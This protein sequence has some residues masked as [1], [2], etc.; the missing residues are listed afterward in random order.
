MIFCI[1]GT[2]H[3]RCQEKLDELKNSFIQKK[4]K[5]GV[6]IVHLEYI[7]KTR[8]KKS[9]GHDE[10]FLDN[11]KQEALATSFLGDKKLIIVKNALKD[12]KDEE[13]IIT[14]LKNNE[15]TIENSLC[16][17]DLIERPKSKKDYPPK[18]ALFHYL[19]GQKFKWEFTELSDNDAL[20]WIKN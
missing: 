2:D 11:L 16:F 13:A 19:S 3:Y 14:F 15:A 4:D 6:N 9:E 5:S 1:Y 7:E 20:R 17:I 12:K 10:N 8:G 18:S